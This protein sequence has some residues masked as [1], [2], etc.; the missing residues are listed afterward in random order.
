MFFDL[1]YVIF[2]GCCIG[3]SMQIAEKHHWD[4]GWAF[5]FTLFFPY[6]ALPIYY[7]R[8]VKADKKLIK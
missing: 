5:V 7:I 1:F 8:G 3:A 2:L 4:K 6:L